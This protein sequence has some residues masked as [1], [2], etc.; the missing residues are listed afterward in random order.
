MGCVEFKRKFIVMQKIMKNVVT[1]SF[2][3]FVFL[4]NFIPYFPP[5]ISRTLKMLSTTTE[6]QWQH[7]F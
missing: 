2:A 5:K 3:I 4:I 7:N 6:S 1:E